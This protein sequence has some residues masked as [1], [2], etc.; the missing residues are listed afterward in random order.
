MTVI[1][2]DAIADLKTALTCTWNTCTSGTAPTV[3]FE[4]DKKV[5]G[6]DS[7]N[8]ER[9][10]I[11]A[12]PED[13]K[14]FALYGTAHWHKVLITLDIRTYQTGGLT[15]QNV[16]VKEVARILKNMLRRNSQGFLQVVIGKSETKNQDYRNMFRHMQDL[17]YD[18]VNSHTFT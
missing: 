3:D 9:I 13:I 8:T 18:D 11:H 2:Y 7:D 16:V 15:R 4:W 6:F 1:V 14:V 17:I 10:I 12:A 5:V